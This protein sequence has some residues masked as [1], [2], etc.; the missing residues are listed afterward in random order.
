MRLFLVSIAETEEYACY[1]MKV[2]LSGT[3][4]R[5]CTFQDHNATVVKKPMDTYVQQIKTK[6]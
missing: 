3:G 6:F 4:T 5:H 1:W 2:L